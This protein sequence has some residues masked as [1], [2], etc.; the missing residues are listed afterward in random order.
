MP[1]W[2]HESIVQSDNC[3][4]QTNALILYTHAQSCRYT[5][6]CTHKHTRADAGPPREATA[7]Y[8]VLLGLLGLLGDVS[9]ETVMSD[10]QTCALPSIWLRLANQITSTHT[11]MNRQISSWMKRI[12]GWFFFRS[13]STSLLSVAVISGFFSP[14]HTKLMD[15][16]L[17]LLLC[18][19]VFIC[20]LTGML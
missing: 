5:P 4:R 16:I 9:M 6:T 15:L 10:L 3:K 1:R 17:G 2:M 11:Q 19:L 13:F 7:Q 20:T 14:A 8:G 12:L 18:C